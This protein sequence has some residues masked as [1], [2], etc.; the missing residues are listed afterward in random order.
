MNEV[1]PWFEVVERSPVVGF[2]GVLT[3]PGG[4]A[5]SVEILA[6]RHTYP[7]KPPRIFLDP[8][9]GCNRLTDGSL[10]LTRVW[11]PDRDTFAQHVVYAAAYLD[12][13]LRQATL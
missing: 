12:Y 13:Q 7:A 6:N 2:K 8:P 1:F 3:G 11:R 10:C 5:Y 4:A 9:F